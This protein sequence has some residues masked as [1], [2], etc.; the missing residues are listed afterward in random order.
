M[1]GK[2]TFLDNTDFNKN[3]ILENNRIK[4]FKLYF[5]NTAGLLPY[6]VSST[7]ITSDITITLLLQVFFKPLFSLYIT[8]HCV[9][10]DRNK[11]NTI[12]KPTQ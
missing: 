11:R 12:K 4:Y 10:Q 1:L 7:R 3:I 2:Q 9:K 8:F 6:S 5:I